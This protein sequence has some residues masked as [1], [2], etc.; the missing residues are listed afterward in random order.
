MRRRRRVSGLPSP[1]ST[2]VAHAMSKARHGAAVRVVGALG[3]RRSRVVVPQ[4]QRHSGGGEAIRRGEIQMT[5]DALLIVVARENL[6]TTEK[7]TT[8]PC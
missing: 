1:A 3:R 4:S 7:A 8:S 2:P 5:E 6:Y